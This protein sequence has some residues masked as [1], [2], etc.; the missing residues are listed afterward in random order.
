MP[1]R[2]QTLSF[3]GTSLWPFSISD[4]EWN[5]LETDYGYAIPPDL[6]SAIAA[7]TQTMRLRSDARLNA[8]P[9][10]EAIRQI[11]GEKRTTVDWL[12]WTEGLPDEVRALIISVDE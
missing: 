3:G 2:K 11:A 8:L 9:T 1:P 10:R 7:K 6:R 5:K 12:K 4:G